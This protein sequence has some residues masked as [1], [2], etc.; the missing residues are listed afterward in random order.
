MDVTLDLTPEMEA[1]LRDGLTRNDIEAVRRVLH[2]AVDAAAESLLQQQTSSIWQDYDAD[3]VRA[4]LA[5]TAGAWSDIDV[6]RMIQDIYR[7]RD[8]GSRPP[9]RP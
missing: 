6:D 1:R 9:M 3:R 8:E 4:A 5:N 2:D 7:A